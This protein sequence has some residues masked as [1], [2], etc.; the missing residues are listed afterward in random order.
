MSSTLKEETLT[1]NVNGELYRKTP[2]IQTLTIFTLTDEHIMQAPHMHTQTHTKIRGKKED[3]GHS[4]RRIPR[5]SVRRSFA[6]GDGGRGLRK[7]HPLPSKVPIQ[8]KF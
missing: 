2:N 6:L 1:Q 3:H 5:L 4:C 8:T 7:A